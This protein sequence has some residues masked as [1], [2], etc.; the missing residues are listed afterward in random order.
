[1]HILIIPDGNRRWAK[2]KGLNPSLG[3]KEGKNIVNKLAESVVENKID[4]LT[5]WVLSKDNFVKRSKGEISFLFKLIE[6]AVKE[7]NSNDFVVKNDIKV[8]LVGDWENIVDLKLKKS[9]LKINKDSEDRK[10][11]CITF[12]FC[13]NGDEETVSAV[14]DVVKNNL[15]ISKENILKNL[16]TSFLPEV[17]I[18]IRTGCENDPHLSGNILMWQTGYSQLVFSEKMFPDFSVSDLKKAIK[19]VEGREKR[20]G[21]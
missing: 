4:Y 19:E 9:L 14:Q 5:F 13:Y 15:K 2:K 17:D 18:L 8:K 7:L 21:S 3:H 20:K 6:S 16:W 11:A 1:M 12:L 10:G